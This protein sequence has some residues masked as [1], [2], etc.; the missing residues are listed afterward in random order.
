M[1]EIGHTISEAMQQAMARLQAGDIGDAETLCKKI[2]DA[3]PDHPDVLH[4]LGVIEHLRGRYNEAVRLLDRALA[5]KPDFA[6]AL[7]ARGNALAALRLYQE[8]MASYSQAL[9]IKPDFA[10]VLYYRGYILGVLNRQQESL[11]SYDRALAIKPDYAEALNDRGTAL[12]T[13]SRL[14]EALASYDRALAIN[15]NFVEAMYNRGY[16]LSSLG[17][18]EEA[19]ESYDQALAIKPDFAEA[20]HNRGNTLVALNRQQEALASYDRALAIKPKFAEALYN[21]GGPLSEMNRWQEALESYERALAIKPDYVD[22]LN[23]RGRVLR[24]MNRRQEA[25]ESYGRALAVNP[26]DAITKFGSCMAE[27]PVLYA[28]EPEIARQRAAYQQRLSALCDDIDRGTLRG[29]L[30]NIVGANQPFLLAYQGYNDRDLQVRY[31]A[32]VCRIMAERYSRAALAL[33]PGPKEPVRIGIVSGHFRWHSVWKAPIKGWISQ[34]DRG[35]FRVSGYYT[36]SQNNS[37]TKEAIAMC[38]R[39]VQ[40]PM[41]LDRWRQT[42]LSDAPHILLYPEIGMDRLSTALAAQRLAA[43]QCV[44]WGH[45]DTSG[46]PTLDYFLSSDLMEPSD[47]QECYTEQLVRLPNLSIYYEPF[48]TS[49]VSFARADVGL[50]PT[51]TVFWCGQSLFKYLPQFDQVFARIAKESGDCQ[52]AFIQYAI[53]T[54]VT[55]LFKQRLERAFAAVGLRADDYCIFLPRLNRHQFA[56]ANGLCDIVLDSIG[57][58][59]FNSTLESLAHNLPIVTMPGPLMRGRH[60]LAILKMMGV[61]ETITETIDDYISVAI[62][63]ARDLP[64]RMAVKDQIAANKHRIYR[65]SACISAMEEFL[66]RAARPGNR[67]Q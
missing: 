8:A 21:R 36:G 55:E 52:F 45:P 37:T 5:I 11:E 20:L 38:D 6:E 57:W 4:M 40:G 18:Q 35:Q 3:N 7:Y 28:D 13:L 39:F 15:P 30:A 53:G 23:D 50:R 43:V 32:L 2:L 29:D 58:S 12:I 31:G 44:S 66:N 25:L 27:L 62:R 17:R 33:P 14:D 41:S 16:T 65:D 56:A 34:L 10:E 54:Q 24:A 60:T 59:G 26:D 61:T 22:A 51:S 42:I 49:P 48:N 47:G 67:G 63:L 64:W 9:A 46:F 1:N 19:L